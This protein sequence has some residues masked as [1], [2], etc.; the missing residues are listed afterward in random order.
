MRFLKTIILA[1]AC[2]FSTNVLLAQNTT[3]AFDEFNK[4]MAKMWDEQEKVTGQMWKE[5]YE[6]RDKCNREYAN[7]LLQPWD[8]VAV[9]PPAPQP[10]PNRLNPVVHKGNK[11]EHIEKIT[12]PATPEETNFLAIFQE[13]QPFKALAEK[14]KEKKTKEN[15]P[16]DEFSFLFY[17]TNL[18][19]RMDNRMPRLKECSSGSIS[20]MW[21]EL[22]K[23]SHDD[24]VIDCLAIK[25][26]RNLCDWAYLKMLQSLGAAYYSNNP[27]EATLLA[28]FIFVQSGYKIKLASY[29]EK[30]LLLYASEFGVYGAVGFLEKGT[31]YFIAHNV[32]KDI[33][34]NFLPDRICVS[35]ASME[36][37]TP[38]SM[39]INKE[40]KFDMN[41]SE[42]KHLHAGWYPEFK[43][44]IKVNRN[45]I[46]FYGKYPVSSL[47]GSSSHMWIT[48]ANTPLSE[49]VRNTLYPDIRKMVE[50]KD[51]SV[52]LSII[53]NLIQSSFGIEGDDQVWGGNRIFFAEETLNYP[54]SD[55]EDR[56]ILF[57]RIVRDILGYE[58]VL[59]HYPGHL[60][61]GVKVKEHIYGNYQILGNDEYLVCDPS[62]INTPIGSVI[63][64]VKGC[65]AKII[66][67][68]NPANQ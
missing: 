15:E 61:C 21:S 30:L 28:A 16:K 40:M 3:S 43:S 62:Y 56:A 49:E 64:E 48:C 57:A 2:T 18:S 8:T 39:T 17:G 60:A 5:Y 45:L 44:D 67:L 38:L 33:D 4:N 63:P 58:V 50:G 1:A 52:A 10:E 35:K 11:P 41:P 12:V 32:G 68:D 25:E 34:P 66:K 54:N 23:R 36:H 46:D 24:M 27:N 20:K 7:F 6:F 47:N 22:S 55:C 9:T 42:T 14:V 31:K 51:T 37:E 13:A 19:V 29:D 65:A 59:L 26:E 53:N